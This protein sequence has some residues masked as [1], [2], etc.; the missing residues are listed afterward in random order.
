MALHCLSHH[1]H[2]FFPK[3]AI[4]YS[5]KTLA[6]SSVLP[7]PGSTEGLGTTQES[8]VRTRTHSDQEF[9]QREYSRKPTKHQAPGLLCSLKESKW[10]AQD[11]W[12]S[13][14]WDSHLT[15][16]CAHP[17]PSSPTGHSIECLFQ[18]KLE[19]MFLLV[20]TSEAVVGARE[21]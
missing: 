10:K 3:E 4:P 11:S 1:S 8:C 2:C 14:K 6:F 19:P 15:L 9:Y 12:R 16:C 13:G 17:P 21:L 18:F 20:S 5:E 7:S